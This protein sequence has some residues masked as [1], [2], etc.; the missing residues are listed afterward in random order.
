MI[1][2]IIWVGPVFDRGGYG[3]MSRNYLLG[4]RRIGFPVRVVNYGPT[5]DKDIHPAIYNEITTLLHTDAG[6]YPI[7][8]VNLTPDIFPNIKFEGVAKKVGC[9]IFETDGVPQ[10]W[11]KYCNRMDELWVPSQFNVETFSR[12]GVDPQKIRVVPIPVDTNFF[13]PQK[14]KLD[15]E[16]Q[17][18]FT[19]LYTFAFNWRKGFDLLLEAYLKEFSSSDEVSLILKVYEDQGVKQ[20]EIKELILRSVA[21]KIDL[22]R[23]DLP[24]YAIIDK[25]LGQ[26]DL[27]KLY[28]ACD[29]YISTDR[30]NGWGMPCMEVMAMGKPAAT[31]DWSGST[32]FMK[33][34]NS[35]LIK[36]TGR[37]IPVD[38]RLVG[39][40][41]VLYSG[42][43]WAE[44]SVDE[45]RRVMRSAF[46][47]PEML[48]A[49]AER[50][51]KD[52]R[53]NFSIESVTRRIVEITSQGIGGERMKNSEKPDALI[54]P[55]WFRGVRKIVLPLWWKFKNA[56]AKLPMLK[57]PS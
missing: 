51:T 41:P 26:E 15:V 54:R 42:Q 56:G 16:G 31:I 1:T 5:H 36:P 40:R 13:T 37:L 32:E 19:F 4:F 48:K 11:V 28:N 47:N 17:K 25:P 12:S 34:N 52:I 29:L 6:P 46:G 55:K 7:G 18:K 8:V 20:D 33:Q 39:I 14:E 44:V 30:A 10:H 27:R 9:T 49:I 53:E 35:L 2:G 24:H 43:K 45:V 22:T 38:G 23:K 21:D 57:S 50:G 3:N